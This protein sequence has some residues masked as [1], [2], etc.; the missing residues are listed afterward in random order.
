MLFPPR[1]AQGGGQAVFELSYQ[2]CALDFKET[3]SVPPFKERWGG[4]IASWKQRINP[5][6]TLR[7]DEEQP[8]ELPEESGLDGPDGP[9]GAANDLSEK[10]QDDDV[11][12]EL[13]KRTVRY[14]SGSIGRK[15]SRQLSFTSMLENTRPIPPTAPLDAT[16]Q[17]NTTHRTY[18]EP[19]TPAPSVH[20]ASIWQKVHSL[21]SGFLMPTTIALVVALPCAL[22][23][24]LK[25]LFTQVD[26]WTGGRI[27]NAP[28]DKPPLSFVLETAVFLG[29]ITI[30]SAL[31]LLGAS[32]A[33]L[34]VSR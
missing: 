15:T 8:V 28:D 30:P 29:G 11:P 2:L 21:A 14:T 6:Q 27:P 16:G 4:R 19:P 22:I 7:H 10:S 5:R 1:S 32:I 33:R 3:K 24:P 13:K 20:K 31:I 25:A 23:Q 18:H 9:E 34:E 12:G 26:G 17:E